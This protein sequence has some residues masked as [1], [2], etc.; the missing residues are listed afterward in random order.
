MTAKDRLDTRLPIGFATHPLWRELRP[1]AREFL[2]EWGIKMG[3]HV[4]SPFKSKMRIG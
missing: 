1:L 3:I 2:A 4:V